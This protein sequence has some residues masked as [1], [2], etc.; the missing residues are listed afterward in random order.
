MGLR[1]LLR[2]ERLG[3]K[4]RFEYGIKVAFS[5]AV[6]EKNQITCPRARMQYLIVNHTIEAGE[7]VV[8][9]E[10]DSDKEILG[11]ALGTGR[12]GSSPSYLTLARCN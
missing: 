1:E 9:S 3:D 10:C 2:V 7:K 4:I 6:Q 5:D 11:G 12:D 8:F